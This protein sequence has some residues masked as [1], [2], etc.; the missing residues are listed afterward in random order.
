MARLGKYESREVQRLSTES[1]REF[2]RQEQRITNIE[3]YL[4]NQLV[5]YLSSLATFV[6]F[7]GPPSPPW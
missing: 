1:E 2:G 4:S 6:G 5:P 7:N 3:N